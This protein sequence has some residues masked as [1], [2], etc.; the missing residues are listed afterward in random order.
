MWLLLLIIVATILFWVAGGPRL[1][2]EAG[3]SASLQE[4]VHLAANPRFYWG[5][6]QLKITLSGLRLGGQKYPQLNVRRLV[7]G[8]LWRP[9]LQGHLRIEQ[10]FLDQPVVYGPW[11]GSGTQE[12][13]S[14]T[15]IALPT[16][17]VIRDGSLYWKS[18]FGH[19]LQMT[20]IQGDFRNP[21][22]SALTGLWTWGPHA[23]HARLAMRIPA[24]HGAFLQNLQLDLANKKIGDTLL[25]QVPQVEK[26]EKSVLVP[27]LRLVWRASGQRHAQL[28]MQNL[29]IKIPAQKL[30]I[31]AVTLHAGTDFA[32][33]LQNAEFDWNVLSGRMAFTLQAQHLPQLARRWG[34]VWPRL[35]DPGAPRQLQMAGTL[36]GENPHFNWT[37]KQGLLDNSPWSGNISGTWQPLKT[38]VDLQ[39]QSLDLSHYLPAPKPGP[40]AVLPEIPQDWPVSGSLRIGHLIW[41]KIHADAV[42]IRSG[43][44][45]GGDAG[46]S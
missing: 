43:D 41:G 5:A 7:L 39:I 16:Q 10:I 34:L 6:R 14:A 45:S 22:L 15:G 44:G 23:G 32:A 46:S 28:V 11:P 38:H 37:I 35:T 25:L 29:R 2:L 9:L 31:A 40:G 36:N 27:Q 42:R 20:A 26:G 1:L 12:Q 4:P 24:R 18:V 30:D 33:K 19:T 21:G 3:I 13:S 17:V 8:L